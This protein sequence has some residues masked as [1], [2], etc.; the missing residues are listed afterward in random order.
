M[1][2]QRRF[3]VIV[4]GLAL[5]AWLATPGGTAR[6]AFV[7]LPNAN[8]ATSGNSSQFFLL[9]TADVTFQWVYAASQLSSV[10]GEQLTSIGFRLPAGAATVGSSLSYTAWNLQLGTSLNPPGSLSSSFAANQG[11]DTTTVLSGPLTIPA[12]S[13][14]GGAGPNPFYDITFTTPH[15]YTGGDL[16]FTLRHTPV[17][18][19]AVNVDANTLP[20]PVTDTVGALGSASTS[21]QAHFFTSPV[22]ALDFGPAVTA[23]PEPFSLT[24]LGIGGIVLAGWRPW[25][26]KATA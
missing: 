1:R 12:N 2:A 10:V 26:K 21:G 14:V 16:L 11:P 22:T 23:V 24:L 4:L 8:A 5:A 17:S 25:R 7:V 19:P 20:N 18:G 13:F 6:A 15:L 3:G 9:D